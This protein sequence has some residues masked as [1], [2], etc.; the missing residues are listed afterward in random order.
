MT[1]S[2]LVAKPRR[3]AR[4]E[5]DVQ[6]EENSQVGPGIAECLRVKGYCVINHAIEAEVLRLAVEAVQDDAVEFYQPAPLVQNGLL[7]LEGS[8]RIA[9]LESG[10]GLEN[11]ALRAVDDKILELMNALGPHQD[12]IGFNCTTRSGCIVHEAS[13][14]DLEEADLSDTEANEWLPIFMS[15]KIMVLTFLGP[16]RGTLELMPFDEDANPSDLATF[17]GQTVI[18]RTDQM[19]FDFCTRGNRSNYVMSCFMLQNDVLRMHRNQAETHLVPVAKEMDAWID[20]RLREIKETEEDEPD[21]NELELT[22]P[23]NFIAAANRTWFKKTQTGVCGFACRQPSCWEPEVM[24]LAMTTGVDVVTDV[25]YCRWDHSHLYDPDPDSWKQQPPKTSCRHASF[26]DGIELF[27]NKL[28]SLSLAETKGM[29]PSQRQ[30]LEVTYDA[31]YRSGMRKSTLSNSSCGMYVGMGTSEWN[32][33]ERTAD[34]GIFGATGGA[35]SICAGRLSFCLGCKGASLAVDTDAASGLSSIF[36]AAESVEKKGLGAIQE[37][38]CGIGV[39]LILSSVWWPGWSASGFLSTQGRSATFDSSADGFVRCEATGAAVVRP[40]E[41]K[42]VDGHLV[43]DEIPLAGTIVGGSTMNSGRTAGMSAPSGATEQAILYEACRKANIMPYD[44][45]ALE[46]HG[47]GKLIPDAVEVASAAKALREG[48]SEEMLLLGSSKSNSG[49][50]MEAGGLVSLC[51]AMHAIRWGI[52]LAN[53]HLRQLN[54]HLDI[55][56]VPVAIADE[57]LEFRSQGVFNG[58]NAHGFGGTLVNILLFGGVDEDLRPPPGPVPEESRPKLAF[59][60]AGGGHLESDSRPRKGFFLVGSWNCW[61]PEQM[62]NQGQGCHSLVIT[63]GDNRWE[64]FQILIDGNEN[65]LLHPYSY[66]S[67]KGTQ[68]H[69]P[70]DCDEIGR[71]CTWLID[72]RSPEEEVPH[73]DG[74]NGLP[75]VSSASSTADV[76]KPGDKYLISIHVAGKWRTVTWRRFEINAEDDAVSTSS[77]GRFYVAGAWNQW[78]F[79]E[80]KSDP[81]EPRLHTLEV[82]LSRAISNFQIV[83]NRDWSQTFAPATRGAGPDTRVLGPED[84]YEGLMWSLAGTVGETY[85]IEFRRNVDGNSDVKQITW[86]QIS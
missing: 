65:K 45:D 84:R 34:M 52:S 39:H 68:I 6:L 19:N 54:P 2:A 43:K 5:S 25:P 20:T 86:R 66:K 74:E 42:F 8:N 40:K 10:E 36:W 17:P 18:L 41:D 11:K 49:N 37:L 72:G 82:T 60:P 13:E 44:I 76:G 71:S 63:L 85:R 50:A 73:N 22:V 78:A 70:S 55:A 61:E 81:S 12:E 83:R 30:T 57:H 16:D 15:R 27:D 9:R 21:W 31:L 3:G 24:F 26:I 23:R 80:M 69:G 32:Y 1:A 33:A 79:D 7:G 56:D 48:T 28:F 51:K 64:Q 53:V 75:L 58:V 67:P 47:S 4:P 38:A 62:V 46:T 14:P 77:T 59:W 35:P 29:D